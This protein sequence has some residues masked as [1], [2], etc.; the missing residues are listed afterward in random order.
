MSYSDDEE[1]EKFKINTGEKIVVLGK[2][3]SGKSTFLRNLIKY[4]DFIFSEK[5]T[6]ILYVYKFYHSYFNELSHVVEFVQSIPDDISPAQHNLLLIDDGLEDCFDSISAWFLRN[7]R[8]SNTTIVLVYQTVFVP[9]SQAFK[10]IINNTDIFIFTYMPRAQSQLAILF[11]QF[12]GSKQEAANALIIY[13]EAMCTKYGYL[14]FDVRQGSC[15]QFRQN[16]FFEN[17]GTE[18]AFQIRDRFYTKST[19]PLCHGSSYKRS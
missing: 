3:N 12:F 7:A 2:S 13:N 10:S 9:N 19:K 11:R 8:H 4:R 17:G 5:V 6:R 18:D 14:V 1:E 15:Y 16:I